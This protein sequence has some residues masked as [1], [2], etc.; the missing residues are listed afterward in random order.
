MNEA[1]DVGV[2]QSLQT[3]HLLVHQVERLEVPQNVR[4]PKEL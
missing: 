3:L 2:P 4:L 1:D